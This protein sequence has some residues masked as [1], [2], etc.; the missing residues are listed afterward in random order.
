MLADL[1]ELAVVDINPLVANHE[2]VIALDARIRI[3]PA[4][5]GGE[6]RFAIRPYPSDLVESRVWQGR[7]V[8]LR[9]IRPEDEA[10]HLAFLRRL[11]PED[12]RMRVF[13]SRRSIERSE[14]RP[15]HPDRLRP[16]DR[17]RGRG[18]RARSARKRSAWC[19]R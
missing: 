8:T 16:R 9:P 17:L 11:D 19:A 1:P 5:P 14:L 7:L 12:I 10:Q 3:D 4:R 13:Y 2:G 15:P 18:A 6:H